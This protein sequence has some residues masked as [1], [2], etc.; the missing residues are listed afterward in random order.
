MR[1][2]DLFYCALAVAINQTVPSIESWLT[3]WLLIRFASP[4]CAL[5][6]HEVS[7]GRVGMM[8]MP[9]RGAPLERACGEGR[10]PSI[11]STIFPSSLLCMLYVGA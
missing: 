7:D 8:T 3:L 6:E 11:L 4:I 9:D 2:E 5:V 1:L 10:P